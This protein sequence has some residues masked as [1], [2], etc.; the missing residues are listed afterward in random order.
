MADAQSYIRSLLEA[1]PIREPVLSSAVQALH[2]PL[3][4]RGLD[5]GCGIGVNFSVYAGRDRR[6]LSWN[7]PITTLSLPIRWFEAGYLRYKA[8]TPAFLYHPQL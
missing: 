4:S 5:A 3:A 8:S 7:S 2:L 6:I 1:N